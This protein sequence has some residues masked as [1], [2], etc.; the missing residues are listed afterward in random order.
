[1]L[2]VDPL[3]RATIAEIRT[4]P[5]FEENLPRYLQPLPEIDRYPT[6]PMDDLSTL[7]MIKEGQADPKKVAESKGLIFTDELGI[8]DAEIVAELLDK[9]TTYTEA[10]VWEALQN[11]GDNQVKVAYQLVRDHKR[12]VQDCECYL[13]SSR[14]T[15]QPCMGTRTRI[16]LQWRSFWHLRRLRGTQISLW[17]DNRDFG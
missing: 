10:M 3:K 1:M 6:L 15:I 17:V 9:I 4:T 5:F 7:L 8:V 13:G 16:R 12:I 2:H 11:D 14:L